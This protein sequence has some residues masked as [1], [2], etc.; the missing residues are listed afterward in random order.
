M[1]RWEEGVG[2]GWGGGRE[3]L[4]GQCGEMKE[5]GGE[6]EWEAKM[7]EW[8]GGGGGEWEE[9]REGGG[10]EWGAMRGWGG[11]EGKVKVEEAGLLSKP[12]ATLH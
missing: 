10:G 8:G 1:G 5:G 7:E 3:G 9:R 6:L 4:Q 2:E 11:G 12:P